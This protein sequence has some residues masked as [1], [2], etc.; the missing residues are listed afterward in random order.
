MSAILGVRVDEVYLEL[1]SPETEKFG[2]L[3]EIDSINLL[4]GKNGSGKT[5]FLTSL[6]RSAVS[7]KDHSTKIYFSSDES[8]RSGNEADRDLCAIYYSALPNRKRL[9]RRAGLIDASPTASAGHDE[10]R[11]L[12]IGDVARELGVDTRLTAF[13]GYTRNLF[14]TVLI[15]ALSNSNILDNTLKLL[16]EEYNRLGESSRPESERSIK[17][18]D[19][20]YE[21]ILSKVERYLEEV[22]GSRI[23]EYH[24]MLFLTCLAYVNERNKEFDAG[25]ITSSF[26]D[27][28]GLISSHVKRDYFE[29][30]ESVVERTKSVL[31]N[32]GHPEDFFWNDR[33]N[34][35]QIDSVHALEAIRRNETPIKIEWSN[36]SSGLYALVEQ[37]ALIDSAI[38]D[39]VDRGRTSIL[40]LVDEGDAYLHLDWQ[41]RYISLIN[42]YLGKLKLNYRLNSLQLILAT[43]SPLLA[44][45]VPDVFVTSLD[46]GF[47]NSGNKTFAA[48]LE[49]VIAQSFESRSLGDFAAS[50]INEIYRRAQKSKLTEEDYNLIDAIG[51]NAIQ[52][53]LRGEM[54]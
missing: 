30:L 50:R 54:Q 2:R 18:L 12:R 26:L 47:P 45:D 29:A 11:L 3:F 42:K 53:I 16:I 33:V 24:K 22:I 34:Y 5:R 1:V 25:R 36:L 44:A 15:P 35:F 28:A 37:F 40:L 32:Y 10:A 19:D 39:A 27:Y 52:S 8:W 13:F 43:H 31:D 46:Q 23:G 9:R 51:D 38:N 17:E 21:K 20:E 6:A 14:R 7:S 41:R 4:L 48:P 49:D